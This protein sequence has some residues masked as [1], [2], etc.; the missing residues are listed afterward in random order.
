MQPWGGLFDGGETHA[1][2]PKKPGWDAR[3]QPV[4][5]KPEAMQ[6][7]ESNSGALYVSC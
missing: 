7:I 5:P 4:A 3:D 1:D 6:L 2:S